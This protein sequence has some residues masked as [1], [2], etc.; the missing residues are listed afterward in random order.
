MP[1]PLRFFV[2]FEV[3][4]SHALQSRAETYLHS[5]KLLGRQQVRENYDAIPLKFF[6]KRFSHPGFLLSERTFLHEPLFSVQLEVFKHTLN[7]PELL[8]RERPRLLVHFPPQNS[9][10][11]DGTDAPGQFEVIPWWKQKT[12]TAILDIFRYAADP[13]RNHRKAAGTRFQ[14]HQASSFPP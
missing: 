2:A 5:V 11:L 1:V 14:V 9:I 6:R 7:R 4:P 12:C 10:F 3:V 13:A 8:Y